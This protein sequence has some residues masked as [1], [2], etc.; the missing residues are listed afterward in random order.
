MAL[1]NCA[2]CGGS[3]SSA[4][5][6]CPHCG[7]PVAASAPVD[8]LDALASAAEMR[9]P[10][11]YATPVRGS[12][13]R[14]RRVHTIEQTSKRW[15]AMMLAGAMLMLLGA[16]VGVLGMVLVQQGMPAAR[17]IAAVGVA[18]IAL[19]VVVYL[20]ARGAAWWENG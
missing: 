11:G 8:P 4:A 1:T 5:S 3:V 10:I 7:H 15:K 2:E 18:L 17:L 14:H 6:A 20:F 9:R 19:G 13:G 12:G 16:A